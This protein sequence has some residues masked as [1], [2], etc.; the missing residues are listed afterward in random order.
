MSVFVGI[1]ISKDTFDV[2]IH[3]TKLHR[4]F[5]NTSAGVAALD[6]WL[7]QQE[8]V[9][10]IALEAT[11]RYGEAVARDLVER[12]YAVS[13]LN[14]KQIHAFAQIPLHGQ[15]TDKQDARCIARFCALHR[16]DLWTPPTRL[17]QRLQQRVRR[18]RALEKMRQQEVNR[19]K[20]GLDDPLVLTQIRQTIAHFEQLIEQMTTALKQLMHSC[21]KLRE[22]QRLLESIPGIGEKTARLLLAEL[23]ITAFESARHL[24]AFVGVTP[25]HHQSGNSRRR[26]S[27]SKQGP[28]HVRAA[29][30]M[31]AVSAQRWN[32]MC[33]ALAQRLEKRRKPGKVIVI[34]VMRKLLHQA[35]GVLNSG[36]R[37]DPN[38]GQ[39]P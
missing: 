3:G 27:I 24:A 7:Q 31:P 39:N 16:P 2:A 10:Q 13:Y 15:K 17:R 5:P 19:L 21:E 36:R 4:K 14:P 34:A 20:S 30:Y 28:S 23:D 32:P 18:I 11:G 29:L 8:P 37:F 38:Y 33:R 6:T 35:F 26:S 22:Q 9:E 1:D 25:T 12:G